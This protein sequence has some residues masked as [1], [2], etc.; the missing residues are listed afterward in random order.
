[1]A[2]RAVQPHAYGAP[3]VIVRMPNRWQSTRGGMRAE[4]SAVASRK[5]CPQVE[6][7]DGRKQSTPTDAGRVLRGRLKEKLSTSRARRQTRAERANGRDRA[8]RGA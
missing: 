7:T 6:C 3:D 5:S 8:R 4:R 2:T 1:M